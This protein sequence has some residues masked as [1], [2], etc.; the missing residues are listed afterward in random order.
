MCLGHLLQLLLT[1]LQHLDQRRLAQQQRG[2]GRLRFW[3]QQLSLSEGCI[4]SGSMLKAALLD[5]CSIWA[6]LLCSRGWQQQQQQRQ[7]EFCQGNQ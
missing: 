3:Q 2:L 7:H 6:S 5:S 1:T 4:Q